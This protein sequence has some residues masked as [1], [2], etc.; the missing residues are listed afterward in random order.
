M[1]GV[2]FL[3]T[4]CRFSI[5]KSTGKRFPSNF[6]RFPRDVDIPMV[7]FLGKTVF[8]RNLRFQYQNCF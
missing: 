1:S 7:D 5:K 3:G 6:G 4:K 8:E 2:G